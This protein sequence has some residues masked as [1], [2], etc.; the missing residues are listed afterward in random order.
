MRNDL[1]RKAV[2]NAVEKALGDAVI[3]TRCG[4][5]LAT[6]AD[7]C[8]AALDDPCPGFVTIEDVRLPITRR[9]YGLRA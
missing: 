9:I 6:Y 3:C 2:T 1:L 5:T 8:S 4:A 7:K